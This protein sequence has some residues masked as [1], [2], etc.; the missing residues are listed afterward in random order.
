MDNR[1][2]STT[3]DRSASPE[4]AFPPAL[5]SVGEAV[6]LALGELVIALGAMESLECL[7]EEVY[8]V[9]KATVLSADIRRMK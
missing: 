2:R 7:I 5:R 1:S 6:G 4:P 8:L 9:S 3:E